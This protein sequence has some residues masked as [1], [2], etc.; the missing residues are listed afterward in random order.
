MGSD[1]ALYVPVSRVEELVALVPRGFDSVELAP[2]CAYARAADPDW[3]LDRLGPL[4]AKISKKRHGAIVMGYSS[5]TDAFYFAHYRAKRLARLLSF[6]DG[7]RVVRGT[8]EPWEEQLDEPPREGADGIGFDAWSV[9]DLAGE[10]YKL[11]GWFESAIEP[12][13]KDTARADKIGEVVRA[14]MEQQR[15]RAQ[16]ATTLQEALPGA[17]HGV[18][19][20][21]ALIVNHGGFYILLDE[22]GAPYVH[23]STCNKHGEERALRVYITAESAAGYATTWE[24]EVMR[25]HAGDRVDGTELLVTA[26]KLGVNILELHWDGGEP[27]RL[28]RETLEPCHWLDRRL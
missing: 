6:A 5:V 17:A 15:A 13:P 14:F 7:W 12:T 2:T 9:C 20:A 11:T 1:C 16:A 19:V 18:P 23:T 8:P 3:D 21:Q 26:A 24:A 22:R 4:A 25:L 10:H 28:L 27:A